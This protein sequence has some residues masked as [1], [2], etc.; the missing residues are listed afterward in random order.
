MQQQMWFRWSG[1]ILAAVTFVAGPALVG[2]GEGNTAQSQSRNV[3]H[4]YMQVP[5]GLSDEEV[6][7][8]I[9]EAMQNPPPSLVCDGA[10]EPGTPFQLIAVRS[11]EDPTIERAWSR[12][13]NWPPV[14]IP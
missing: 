1:F 4:C 5:A 6:N 3:V 14:Q 11:G 9:D 10:T 12:H 2:C 13:G 8:L 7:S